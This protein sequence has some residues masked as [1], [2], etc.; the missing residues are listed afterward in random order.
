MAE[1]ERTDSKL[2]DGMAQSGGR[3]GPLAALRGPDKPSNV[4]NAQ[5]L[6]HGRVHRG[7]ADHLF[8]KLTLA[9]GVTG[10]HLLVLGEQAV[11]C[12]GRSSTS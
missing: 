4:V 10:A 7:L 2:T 8:D 9:V 3:A 6:F 12:D 5:L 1:A 11:R